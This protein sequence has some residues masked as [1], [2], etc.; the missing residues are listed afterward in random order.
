MPVVV[1]PDSQ[2]LSR[3][4][5]SVP[6]GGHGIDHADRLQAWLVNRSEEYLVVLGPNVDL[7]HALSLADGMRLTRPSTSVVLV[8]DT[9]D[10]AVLREAMQAGIRDVVPADDPDAMVRELKAKAEGA[11]A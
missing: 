6:A 7:H 2:V 11:S 10:A 8:R 1:D 4:L 3:L 9:V 5:A